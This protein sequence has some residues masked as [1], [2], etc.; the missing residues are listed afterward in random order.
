MNLHFLGITF[1][2]KQ[3]LMWLTAGL[4]VLATVG[5]W[6]IDRKTPRSD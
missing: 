2:N 3:A 4:L 5:I 6:W 1:T